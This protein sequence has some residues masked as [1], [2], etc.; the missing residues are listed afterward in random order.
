[1]GSGRYWRHHLAN[2][3]R[4]ALN[5]DSHTGV[6]AFLFSDIEGSTRLWEQEP[7]RM[8][9]A[10]A[11]HDA[12]A[13]AAVEAN[14]G[15]IVKTT[16][17]GFHAAFE[18]SLDALAAALQ[19]Q[20]T[21][22]D[23]TA[24]NGVSLRVRCG[25][26][27]GVVERRDN[28]FFGGVVNRAARIM[29]AA[30]GSQ[31]LLSQTAVALIAERL[32][33]GVAFRD[34]GSVRLRDLASP[35][36]I[37]Q[38][39]HPKLQ[40]DFPALRSLEATPNNLPQQVTSFVGRER[41]LAEVKK[42]LGR[43]RLLT[44]VGVGGLG[45]TRLSLQLAANLLDDYPD[46]VWFVELAPLA[47][48][49][50]V[51]QA[52]ATVLGVKEE[53]GR[54]VV[55]P[56]VKYVKDRELLL[57]LDN[58]EHL[59]HACAELAKQLLQA[60]AYLKI[61]A[62]S[63]EHLHIA[64]E[65]TYSVPSLSTPS[66]SNVTL[67]AFREYEA[68]RLFTER[69]I[70][71]QPAFQM[72]DRNVIAVADICKRLD[73]IPLAIELAAAR[74]RTLPIE[75]VA[76]RLNDRFRLLRDGD[77]TGLPHQQ[78]LRSMIDWSYDLLTEHERVLLRRLAVFAGGWTLQAAEAVSVDSEI[79]ESDVVDLLGHLVEKSLVEFDAEGERY[80]LLETVRHYAQERLKESSEEDQS[81]MR[82][83]VFF[84]ALAEKA[85][86]KM[87]GPEQG[88]WLWQLDLEREN[89]LAA[90]G[91][92]ARAAGGAEL[93]L[94]L[95]Y[96][97]AEYWENRGGLELGYRMTV[98]AL[99]RAGATGRSLV[100]CQAL[101]AAG[102]LGRPM[103]RSGD[104]R[105]Y[106]EESLSIAR[107]IGDKGS[108]VVALRM[109]G[110]VAHGQGNLDDAR[111]HYEES[112][113]MALELNDESTLAWTLCNLADLY[114]LTGNL[115]AAQR[116]Y[117]QSLALVREQGDRSSIATVLLNLEMVSIGRRIKDRGRG[118]LLEV[119]A[120][121]EEIGSKPVGRNMLEVSAGLAM[122]HEEWERAA[123]LFGAADAQ[124]GPMG[125][126]RDPADEAFLTPMIA[127]AREVLGAT[128]YATAE[129][130]GR[131]LSYEDAMAETRAWLEKPF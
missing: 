18:D 58:C 89:L 61:L 129:A 2:V 27:A 65:L 118:V 59:V 121:A 131:A 92:C 94:R 46:G 79:N 109:L 13:R 101:S 126:G 36:R 110:N 20:Q 42:L 5:A 64:G 63:R 56:L 44:L 28:D 128:A 26:H 50:L 1:M 127:K 120:I 49:R 90:H 51:P 39:I 68:A 70:A 33:S 62:S 112:L 4:P 41:A 85:Q 9:L 100:R 45:K 11:C 99:T 54:P 105:R 40:Q 76:S 30:H 123:R 81:R 93:G 48:G 117:E 34:L 78:T 82:H 35:E 21:L 37:Y 75:D 15:T 108:I 122:L 23:P 77:P 107:E 14:R 113:A 8:R 55:E 91:W 25:V 87:L 29:S 84:L 19:L 47:D 97:L 52:V 53:A 69:A 60:G 102:R 22:A 24:T 104:A 72:T 111:G 98:E 80:R 95:V 106:L 116:L 12:L 57:I 119:L 66:Q 17:D 6:V 103:G 7:S 38:L 114:R 86:P 125:R 10:L 16:G 96:A 130:A 88:A 124:L 73:G 32:P 43:T 67:E 115:Q 83:L 74:V 31:V 3:A 71:A